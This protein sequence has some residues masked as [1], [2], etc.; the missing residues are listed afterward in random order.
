MKPRLQRLHLS[1]RKWL[2]VSVADAARDGCCHR[3]RDLQGRYLLTGA[4]PDRNARPSL[5][6]LAIFRRSKS[7]AC[8]VELVS[9]RRQIAEEEPAIGLRR[10]CLG[11]HAAALERDSCFTDGVR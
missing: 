7:V 3:E 5:P 9:A 4:Q 10:C 6:S 11:T 8:D 2:P 1:I